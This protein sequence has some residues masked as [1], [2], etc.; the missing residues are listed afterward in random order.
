MLV[1]SLASTSIVSESSIADPDDARRAALAGADAVLV[2]TAI[3]RAE[4]PS[5]LL[6]SLIGIGWPA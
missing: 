1:R 5:G 6:A 4:D 3:L 2:G